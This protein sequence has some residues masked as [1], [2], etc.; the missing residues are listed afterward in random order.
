M[1]GSLL[2]SEMDDLPDEQW[3]GRLKRR[4]PDDPVRKAHEDFA[5]SADELKTVIIRE[6]REHWKWLVAIYLLVV[7]IAVL[8]EW[9]I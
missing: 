4:A 1:S 3:G 6:A 5:R 9:V 2:P 7:T 8:F